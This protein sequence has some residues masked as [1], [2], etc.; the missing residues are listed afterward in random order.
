MEAAKAVVTLLG[1]LFDA[2]ELRTLTSTDL[3]LGDLG[4]QLP[5]PGCSDAQLHRAVIRGL[6]DA[7]KL[8]RPFFAMLR[9]L[10][11]EQL[12]A[13]QQAERLW[14]GRRVLLLYGGAEGPEPRLKSDDQLAGRL[15]RDLRLAGHRPVLLRPSS[16]PSPLFQH[17]LDSCDA[18]LLILS[19][20]SAQAPRTRRALAH[21]AARRSVQALPLVFS[22]TGD[23]SPPPSDLAALQ[24]EEQHHRCRDEA[25]YEATVAAVLGDL[26]RLAS[27]AALAPEAG[28]ARLAWPLPQATA[29][30][31]APASDSPPGPVD[32]DAA[33]GTR[34]R[35]PGETIAQEI[36]V[37]PCQLLTQG[38]RQLAIVDRRGAQQAVLT[39]AA[40][41]DHWIR[42]LGSRD[43][44]AR[45]QA[46]DAH[47][48][49][50]LAG[51]SSDPPQLP[52]PRL[53]WGG[54]GALSLVRWRGSDWV[55]LFFR[56]IPPVGWNLPLGAS[57]PQ[58]E[59]DDPAAWGTRELLEELLVVC[60]TPRM[61]EPLGIRPLLV[62][63]GQGPH[64]ALDAALGA[65]LQHLALRERCD[66]L[67]MTSG[68]AGEL[69]DLAWLKGAIACDRVPTRTD[70]LLRS[71]RGSTWRRNLLVAPSPL[72]LGI[73]VAMVLRWELGQDDSLLDGELLEH[74][75][76]SVELVRMPVA[77]LSLAAAR[78]LF[79]PEAPALSATG[80]LPASL[81]A[82][83]LVAG[84]LH[85]FSWDLRRRRELALGTRVT[86]R[87][88]S[89][90]ERARHRGWLDRFGGFFFDGSG[91]P[92][93]M[94]PC[95]LFVPAT[96]RLLQSWLRQ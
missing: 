88:V 47:L 86:D 59:L 91:S 38:N 77:L 55:P 35:L 3:Y 44:L 95:P 78:R 29:R 84:D 75:D 15:E 64:A 89:P 36:L 82:P 96:A 90:S 92:A 2:N 26:E 46:W 94:D 34:L 61:A 21:L 24:A 33:F 14:F 12:P 45:A 60:G 56:D 6:A 65:C 53:R 57:G 13:I 42:E 93:P 43:G 37:E 31:P 25:A 50:R 58:D 17:T 54:A 28:L 19:S 74:P 39:G 22:A 9:N 63:H 7:G 79:G 70:L 20:A 71:D 87:D 68:P 30:T 51:A 32:R 23:D 41:A 73:D 48:Q 76:G 72:E 40:K 1:S 83:G 52:S 81:Q 5:E 18:L 10:R 49:A 66:R 85:V 62:D 8:G 4:G 67:P 16:A 27:S 80:D 11:R 69:A